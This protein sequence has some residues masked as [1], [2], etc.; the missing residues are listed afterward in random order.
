MFIQGDASDG[1]K[2]T[3]LCVQLLNNIFLSECEVRKESKSLLYD[4]KVLCPLLH[5]HKH[6]LSSVSI[7]TNHMFQIIRKGKLPKQRNGGTEDD[8]AFG[9]WALRIDNENC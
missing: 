7:N 3:W 9:R 1:H 6:C 2:T 5:Y 8:I 4:G